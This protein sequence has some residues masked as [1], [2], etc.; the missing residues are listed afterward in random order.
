LPV[1]SPELQA[2]SNSTCK[3]WLWRAL[4][5]PFSAR[6]PQACSPDR[7]VDLSRMR[8]QVEASIWRA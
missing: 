7:L 6:A 8:A 5:R 2:A 3:S 4:I 1:L